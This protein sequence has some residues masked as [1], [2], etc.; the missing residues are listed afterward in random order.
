MERIKAILNH[1][2]DVIPY[3]FFGVCTTVINVV[4]YWMASHVLKHT[5]VV[6]TVLAW[7][8]AVLFAYITNRKWVF[9]SNAKD[10]SGILKELVSF[11]SCRLVT[12]IVDIICMYLF[13]DILD[14]NDVI[15][16][17]GANVLV[18]ILNYIASK[19]FIFN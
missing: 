3:L 16:K 13:V 5:V 19:W 17:F 11:F 14:C 7:I 18:I 2:K 10:I 8:I 15:I 9:H 6:S 4:V 1:Y 12:G